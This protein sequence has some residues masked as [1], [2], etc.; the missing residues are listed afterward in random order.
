MDIKVKICGLIMFEI[1]RVVVEVGVIY[2]GFN[3]FVKLLCYVVFEL[4]C[5]FVLDML[6]G[7]VKVGFVVNVDDVFL[8]YLIDIVFLDMI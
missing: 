8:D 2:V 5:V 7:V 3:F 1:I 6:V 4:V